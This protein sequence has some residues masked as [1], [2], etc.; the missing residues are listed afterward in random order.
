MRDIVLVHIDYMNAYYIYIVICRV[1]IINIVLYIFNHTKRVKM[2][3]LFISFQ[4]YNEMTEYVKDPR[5]INDS[6]ML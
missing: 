1:Y 2:R 5:N 6:I 3:L 4:K